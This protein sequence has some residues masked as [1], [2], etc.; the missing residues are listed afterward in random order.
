MDFMPYITE[1]VYQTNMLSLAEGKYSKYYSDTTV[2]GERQLDYVWSDECFAL[3]VPFLAPAHGVV[4]FRIWVEG[5][6][7]DV[8]VDKEDRFREGET[9][10]SAAHIWDAKAGVRRLD[11]EKIYYEGEGRTL[12]FISALRNHWWPHYVQSDSSLVSDSPFN[13]IPNLKNIKDQDPENAPLFELQTDNLTKPIPAAFWI[14]C[15]PEGVRYCLWDEYLE[16]EIVVEFVQI[17]ETDENDK[18]RFEYEL[19]EQ[20]RM[21]FKF[22]QNGWDLVDVEEVPDFRYENPHCWSNS[23]DGKLNRTLGIEMQTAHSGTQIKHQRTITETQYPQ[24]SGQSTETHTWTHNLVFDLPK[25][26]WDH[27]PFTGTSGHGTSKTT[28]EFDRKVMEYR[29]WPESDYS[30][31][32]TMKPQ[33]WSRVYSA[34]LNFKVEYK[35]TDNFSSTDTLIPMTSPFYA[36]YDNVMPWP[37]YAAWHDSDTNDMVA[38]LQCGYSYETEFAVTYRRRN[39]LY[40]NVTGSEAPQTSSIER[41]ITADD[42]YAEWK[43]LFVSLVENNR[44]RANEI[45]AELGLK[46]KEIAALDMEFLGL[47][48]ESMEM[49]DENDLFDPVAGSAGRMHVYNLYGEVVREK[50]DKKRSEIQALR[51]EIAGLEQEANQQ[52]ADLITSAEAQNKRSKSKR[53]DVKAAIDQLED[54]QLI[55]ELKLMRNGEAIGTPAA[56]SRIKEL[57]AEAGTVGKQAL[58][59]KGHWY[60]QSAARKER[61]VYL[62][63]L[64]NANRAANDPR[65]Q[66]K[67]DPFANSA[68]ADRHLAVLTM[69]DYVRQHPYDASGRQLL[70]S[71]ESWYVRRIQ[72]KLE[73]EKK[74]SLAGFCKYLELR[75]FKETEPETWADFVTEYA[76]YM[77]GAGP[78]N[79]VLGIMDVPGIQA[80]ET[81]ITQASIAK[82]H[83][84]LMLIQRMLRNGITLAEIRNV[85]QKQ[86]GHWLGMN[87][88]TREELPP[89]KAWRLCQD[90]KETFNE[91]YELNTLAA[92]NDE[93]TMQKFDEY[94]GRSLYLEMDPEQSWSEFVGDAA[95]PRNLVELWMGSK[96][97]QGV[98]SRALRLDVLGSRF[99]ATRIGARLQGSMAVYA[100]NYEKASRF[101]K[102][103]KT[104]DQLAAVMIL[105]GGGAYLADESNIPGARMLV[106]VMAICGVHEILGDL[107]ARSGVSRQALETAINRCAIEAAESSARNKRML[108][109]IDELDELTQTVAANANSSKGPLMEPDQFK[110]LE[111]VA[112]MIDDPP[113]PS[114]VA[115][116]PPTAATPPPSTVTAPPSTVTAPP[117]TVTAPPSTVAAVPPTAAAPPSTVTAPGSTVAGPASDTV[118][119]LPPPGSTVAEGAARFSPEAI[120]KRFVARR[121]KEA[122]LALFDREQAAKD[123][124]EQA[125][126]ALKRG[127]PEEAARLVK[128]ARRLQEPVS[129]EIIDLTKKVDQARKN[130]AGVAPRK[131]L[132]EAPD[133]ELSFGKLKKAPK[134]TDKAAYAMEHS[135]EPFRKADIAMR[136]NKLDDAERLFREAEEAA[137]R[138][139]QTEMEVLARQRKTTMTKALAKR[140]QRQ[141]LMAGK[142]CLSNDPIPSSVVSKVDALL[143]NP[144][145]K[146]QAIKQTAYKDGYVYIVEIDGEKY[147]LKKCNSWDETVTEHI[148]SEL[149]RKLGVDS[150]GTLPMHLK[151]GSF[152]TT[153]MDGSALQV[154]DAE[155]NGSYLLS[156]FVPDG[157]NMHNAREADLIAHKQKYAIQRVL[158]AWIADSDGH[159]GNLMTDANGQLHAFDFGLGC[160]RNRNT[161][162]H[163][164]YVG[165]TKPITNPETY[166]EKALYVPQ[167]AWIRSF[168]EAT[169][170]YTWI[171]RLDEML[172]FETEVKPAIDAIR[173]LCKDPDGLDTILQTRC[174]RPDGTFDS[175][176]AA[177][178]RDVL[179]KRAEKLDSALKKRLDWATENQP[180]AEYFPGGHEWPPGSAQA[181]PPGIWFPVPHWTPV[182]LLEM[183]A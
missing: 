78:G 118:A 120:E 66:P 119:L 164:G 177:E 24:M 122:A 77:W 160:M 143:K 100:S 180:D 123:T 106:D 7:A 108:K 45:L 161:L 37:N 23:W 144:A 116:I 167:H 28:K 93:L 107:I 3:H 138:N 181:I 31:K 115:G 86:L 73:R 175:Q 49:P 68:R 147:M 168:G 91:V 81:G 158:R 171:T 113:P 156:R 74:A 42:G 30:G 40:S 172:D 163:V 183:A 179:E 96:T 20:Q 90:M 132:T 176:L 151:L 111:A 2:P 145:G 169:D 71:M 64:Q 44:T 47:L 32:K 18:I 125:V 157:Q 92:A 146:V 4:K 165:L 39:K 173:K 27:A 166:M 62:H 21:P 103:C 50:M 87:T 85:S 13:G 8:P 5:L 159:L 136:Q 82:N 99:A 1:A 46:T 26:L 154:S 178:M 155:A 56:L 89:H 182:S 15:R 98:L 38:V 69:R 22:R 95:S 130:L 65:P 72:K 43:P 29:L 153:K 52:I 142:R 102:F 34:L 141:A 148:S 133:P 127:D 152:N 83:V 17:A 14:I 11:G 33:K 124:M 70:T 36:D 84:S 6:E 12:S 121:N 79:V 59:A 137:R 140:A 104:T 109:A 51:G 114:T 48:A 16:G 67:E 58:L 162:K 139:G 41:Q 61:L 129:D 170:Q 35:K 150:P 19:P 128:S 54:E 10:R 110:K 63:S 149:C 112:G 76:T 88:P 117:S 126:A 80:G 75:D 53:G 25:T 97:G 105:Y 134:F 60:W 101:R 135:G 57:E 174:L 9:E 55:L 94:F 131:P